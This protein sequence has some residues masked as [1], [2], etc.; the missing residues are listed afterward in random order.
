MP[1][2]KRPRKRVAARLLR[3]RA[4]NLEWKEAT[5]G[6]EETEMMEKDR[7][8]ISADWYHPVMRK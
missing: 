3:F 5:M 1:E 7:D 6:K 2:G 4:S 8:G